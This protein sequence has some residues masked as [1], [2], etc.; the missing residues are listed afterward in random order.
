MA[1][2]QVT[3]P[4]SLREFIE[5][6][7]AAGSYASPSEY[8]EAILLE[9]QKRRAWESLEPLVLEGLASPAREMTAADWEELRRSIKP[10]KQRSQP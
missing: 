7:V 5:A 9:A 4:E 3:L 6:E 2:L 1:V 8:I 10:T